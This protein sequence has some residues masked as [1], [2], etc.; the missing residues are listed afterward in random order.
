MAKCP[1]A[2]RVDVDGHANKRGALS[3]LVWLM[4]LCRNAKKE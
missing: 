1:G 3:E 2:E 4:L